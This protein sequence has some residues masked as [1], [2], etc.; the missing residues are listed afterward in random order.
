MSVKD[1]VETLPH[2]M[3]K[4]VMSQEPSIEDAI[5]YINGIE[6]S[7]IIEKLTASDVLVSRTWTIEE[8]RSAIRYYKNF[9][10]LNKKYLEIHP[11]IPPS[12]EIDEIWHHHIL[13]TRAYHRDCDGIFG[14]YFHHYPYFGTRGEQDF[15]NLTNAFEITQQLHH[16]EFGDY[17]YKIVDEFDN[18]KGS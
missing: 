17:I 13:D 7:G 11:V 12:M 18:S 4:P 1:I 16:K 8:C 15:V 2:S 5:I 9:L 14:Y 3:V 6:F 10:I